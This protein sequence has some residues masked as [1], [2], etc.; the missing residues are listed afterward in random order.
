[1]ILL[2]TNEE[3]ITADIIVDKLNK[4][5]I[6]YY[7]FNTDYLIEKIKLNLDFQSDKYELIDTVK[8]QSFN[9]LNFT[10]VYYRRPKLPSLEHLP[11]SLSE[12]TFLLNEAYFLLEGCYKI[13]QDKFWIS[14]V[15]S[16]REAENKI[17]QLRLAK[18]IGFTIP[19]SLI[20][21]IPSQA[22]TFSKNRPIIIK[23]IKT[24]IIGDE[25]E[26][27]KIIF[28][29][30]LPQCNNQ[31]LDRSDAFPVYLQEKIVKKADIRVTVVGD[32]V[33]PTLI[34]S[35]SFEEASVDWRKG[36]NPNLEFKQHEL[37]KN[38]I[39]MCLELNK[40]LK[41]SFSAIDLVLDKNG[42]YVFLEINPNG[43][44][45]WIEKRTGYKISD[46]IVKQLSR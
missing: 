22:K 8:G 1:M 7:R 21:S 26:S 40:Y 17:Y 37:P 5:S 27:E 46:E 19:Q 15:F 25:N 33:F 2:I 4:L 11:I 41:I 18:E 20:T 36:S 14:S 3:D 12:K 10:S 23:P 44:W 45:G 28:T 34:D 42:K 35:Q 38:I 13:L 31:L 6:P 30:A 29:S 32:K 16:I 24:G 43:Q 39:E 9:L